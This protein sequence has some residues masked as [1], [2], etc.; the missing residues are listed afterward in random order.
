[1]TQ[2]QITER[3]KKLL[4]LSQSPNENEALLA[5]KRA[6]ELM[7]KYQLS[8]DMSDLHEIPIKCEWVTYPSKFWRWKK[9]LLNYITDLY[10]CT[11]IFSSSY[12][13]V[14]KIGMIGNKLNVQI[15]KDMYEYLVD[16]I[17][18]MAIGYA[19]CSKWSYKLGLTMNIVQRISAQKKEVKNDLDKE[20]AL[21]VIEQEYQ[22]QNRNFID[23]NHPGIKKD[24]AVET[25]INYYSYERGLNDGDKISINKQIGE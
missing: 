18:K 1:M 24:R 8:I 7:T 4:R 20:N 21:I 11:Y 6:Y 16:A 13:G 10:Y 5:H 22:K 9:I 23:K 25:N 12:K 17:E 19:G 2:Q 15:A 3:V 14:H